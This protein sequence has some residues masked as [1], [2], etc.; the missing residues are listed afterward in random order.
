MYK[1]MYMYMYMCMC[2]CLCMC[3][4]PADLICINRY[5]YR[6]REYQYWRK[7]SIPFEFR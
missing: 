7:I 4:C 2:M 1:Y 3:M 5:S 6:V